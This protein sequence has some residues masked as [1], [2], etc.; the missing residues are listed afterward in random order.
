MLGH[1]FCCQSSFLKEASMMR[2]FLRHTALAGAIF[3]V[4]CPEPPPLVEGVCGNGALEAGEDCDDNNNINGDGCDQACKIEG[5]INPFCGDTVLDAGEDCDDGNNIDGDGCA[6]D[7]TLEDVPFNVGCPRLVEL[8]RFCVPLPGSGEVLAEVGPD[9]VCG[10]NFFPTQGAQNAFEV[11]KL[12][13]DVILIKETNPNT[14]ERPVMTLF[15][16]TDKALLFDSGHV[17]TAASDVI[18]PFLNGRPVELINTHLHADHIRDNANFDVI[19]IDP[20]EVF[21]QENFVA[22]HCGIAATDFNANHEAACNAGLFNPPA[23]EDLGVNISYNVIRVVRNEHVIDLGGHQITVL[24]TPGHSRTS[25][26]LHDTTRKLLFTGDTLYPDTEGLPGE[27]G[28][29]LVHPGGSDF[30]NYLATAGKYAALEAEVIAVV[31]AHSQGVMPARSLG[32]FLTFVQNRV[33]NSQVSDPQGCDAGN[34][35]IA[36]FPP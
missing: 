30:N 11:R 17:T 27:S 5:V 13:D 1:L 4:A 18:A 25:I 33:N 3:F 29:P 23:S 20:T 12:F 6:A 21:D 2:L 15:L 22:Q 14:G 10:A 9:E 36:G 26:T 31:G 35:S 16:G 34:F 28:I 7:C 24:F 19:A 32:A 8:N